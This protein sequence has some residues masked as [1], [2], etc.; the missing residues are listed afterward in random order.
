MQLGLN[1]HLIAPFD[2][3]LWFEQNDSGCECNRG[4]YL[5][6]VRGFFEQTKHGE[7]PQRFRHLLMRGNRMHP[8]RYHEDT[9]AQG[10]DLP[11]GHRYLSSLRHTPRPNRDGDEFLNDREHGCHY[12]GSDAPGFSPIQ[13]EPGE[14]IRFKL[15]FKGAA[16]DAGN[17]RRPIESSWRKWS[18]HGDYTAPM[19]STP[20]PDPEPTPTPTPAPEPTSQPDREPSVNPPYNG[21]TIGPAPPQHMRPYSPWC[22]NDAIGCD[23]HQF[24]QRQLRSSLKLSEAALRQAIAIEVELLNKYRPSAPPKTNLHELSPSQQRAIKIRR[25]ARERVLRHAGLQGLINEDFAN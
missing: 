6:L 13:L 3:Q 2:M 8:N 19:P 14:R 15:D 11:Y 23:T 25:S 24:M 7:S 17:G 4:E 1:H 10:A 20:T 12:K 18:V 21:P 16:V 9:R 5:Q 22:F